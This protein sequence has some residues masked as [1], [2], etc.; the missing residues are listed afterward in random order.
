MPTLLTKQQIQQR[1]TELAAQVSATPE[2]QDNLLVITVLNGAMFFSCDLLKQLTIENV[3]WDTIRVGSYNGTKRGELKFHELSSISLK[4]KRILV[5]E[6]II[7]SGNTIKGICDRLYRDG[8]LSI[9]ICSLLVRE[10]IPA[11]ISS[12]YYGFEIPPDIFVEGYGLDND[13]KGR[14]ARD[15]SY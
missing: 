11:K 9:S 2:F 10:G 8:P 14:I 5:V 7:D 13:Q 4:D 12:G 15:I 1:I 6:D 3:H